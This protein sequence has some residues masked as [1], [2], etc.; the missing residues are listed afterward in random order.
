MGDFYSKDDN[1]WDLSVL[2]GVGG[3]WFFCSNLSLGYHGLLRQYWDKYITIDKSINVLLVGD[4][5]TSKKEFNLVYKNWNIE[6]TDLYV[7]LKN[8]VNC[9]IVFDTC[10]RETKLDQK[11]DLIINQANLEHMY[12]PFQA[13]YNLVHAL[14][15]DGILLTHTHPPAMPYHAYPRDYFRFMKD[16]WYDLPNYIKDIELYELYSYNNEHVF[17]MYKKIN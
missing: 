16:W 17:T 4:N 5:N 2:R 3:P 10:S 7:D 1:K 15:K 11:Y 12:D 6:T 9:D 13:M 14:K 8:N